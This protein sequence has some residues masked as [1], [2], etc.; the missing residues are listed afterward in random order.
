MG[1]RSAGE[2]WG[3]DGERVERRLAGGRYGT[4]RSG[5]VRQRK[6]WDGCGL[7]WTSAWS[8]AA[9]LSCRVGGDGARRRLSAA[10]SVLEVRARGG[11]QR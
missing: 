2:M 9:A 5:G 4:E 10:W 6:W 7:R 11:N 3:S 8:G 1:A